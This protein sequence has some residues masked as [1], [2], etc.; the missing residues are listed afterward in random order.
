MRSRAEAHCRLKLAQ[1][2]LAVVQTGLVTAMERGLVS[3]EAVA[4]VAVGWRGAGGWRGAR[5]E[6]AK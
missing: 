4:R 2:G 3:R 5:V 1:T 6:A